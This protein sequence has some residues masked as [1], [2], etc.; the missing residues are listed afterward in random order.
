M[1]TTLGA[2]TDNRDIQR[3]RFP[4]RTLRREQTRARILKAAL[5]LFRQ[6]G[7]GAATM[8]AIADAADV[9]VTT[10]FT[11]FKNKRDLAVSLYDTSIERLEQMVTEAQ[12]QRP[13]FEFFRAVTLNA[14]RAIEGEADPTMTH[15]R[16]LLRDPE[17]T[18]AWFLY[19]QRQVALLAGYIAHDY[20]LDPATDYRP[21]LASNL[22]VMSGWVSHRRWCDA[23]QTLDLETETV[24]AL[25]IAERMVL[26]VLAGAPS[27]SR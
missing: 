19:E 20:G 18:Y 27:T 10:L 14:A 13:F 17:L 22:L 21:D 9:H 5:K 16:E 6:V 23:P 15:W 8:N 26:S 7:Y 24:K 3:E 25:D 2:L 4:R 11:H 12:G 1:T